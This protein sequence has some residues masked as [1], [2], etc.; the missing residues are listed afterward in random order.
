[1]KK[2]KVGIIGTGSLG[3]SIAEAIKDSLSDHYEI[4]GV[5]S[6]REENSLKLAEKVDSKAYDNIDQMIEDRPDYIIEAAG[7]E[8]VR[9]MGLKILD[10]GIN[11]I[12]LSVGALADEEF[13]QELKKTALKNKSRIYIP[14]GA[15]GGFDLLRSSLLMEDMEISISTEKAPESLNGAPFLKGRELSKEKIEKLYQGSAREA[16]ELF[17]NNVN[18]AV[19][20]ALAGIGVDHTRVSIHS[21]PGMKSNKHRIQARGETMKIDLS[22]E[23]SPSPKNPR[24]SS[25]AAYSVIAIL[26]NLV[27][28]LVF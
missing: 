15:V 8:I 4:L 7:P 11:F 25:L 5:L 26:E 17:P 2:Y 23:A 28:P 22:I 21:V 14:S 24:S 1:M 13:L 6:R 18:V 27:S 3:T 12:P 19:A 20:T 9:D 10:K 16:I